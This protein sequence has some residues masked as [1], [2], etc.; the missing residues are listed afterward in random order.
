MAIGS[1]GRVHV[2][3]LPVNSDGL[4]IAVD[5]VLPHDWELLLSQICLAAGQRAVILLDGG[6]GAGKS[7][8]AAQLVAELAPVLGPVQLVA[9]DQL[10]AGWGGLAEGSRLVTHEVLAAK[11]GYHPWDWERDRRSPWVAL[12]PASHL[13][14]EGCGSLTTDTAAAATTRLWLEMDVGARKRRALDRDGELFRPWW[15]RWAVQEQRHWEANNPR[16]L[17]DLI[18]TGQYEG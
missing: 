2:H 13:L 10:Y 15:D 17:A 5:I 11:P 16:A 1:D 12:D 6:S 14:V 7:T 3:R 18:V 8:L 9:M 4:S